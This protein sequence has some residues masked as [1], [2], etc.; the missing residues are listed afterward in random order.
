MM[1]LLVLLI[2]R[3]AWSKYDAFPQAGHKNK[4]QEHMEFNASA[5]TDLPCSL[6]LVMSY[7]MFRFRTSI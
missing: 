3:E 7:K 4:H 1:R 2:I 5:D 6:G